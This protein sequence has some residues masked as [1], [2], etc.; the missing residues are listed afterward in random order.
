METLNKQEIEEFEQREAE[1][2]S[3][4]DEIMK[5]ND[6]RNLAQDIT[7]W[8]AD[9]ELKRLEEKA[10]AKKLLVKA[11]KFAKDYYDFKEL[12]TCIS[13]GDILGEW[14]EESDDDS[15]YE[16][17]SISKKDKDWSR[18][19]FKEAEKSLSEFEDRE[20]AAQE[21]IYLAAAVDQ[22]H[23]YYPVFIEEDIEKDKKWA[24]DLRANAV[25]LSLK[26]IKVDPAKAT[27]E[28]VIDAYV[29]LN[30]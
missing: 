10:W 28:Q 2:D 13:S 4:T 23:E 19:L 5:S 6:Y 8:G 22:L 14:I 15:I 9:A 29:K 30:Q 12:G 11:E 24:L 7:G 20:D 27:I 26:N 17:V 1:I 16:G 3:S 18:K 21:M 25:K